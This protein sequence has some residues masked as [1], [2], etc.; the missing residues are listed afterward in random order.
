VDARAQAAAQR[1]CATAVTVPP[2]ETSGCV[3][4]DAVDAGDRLHQAVATHG[5]VHV[6]R[7]QRR[8][9]EPG[10][11]NVAYDDELEDVVGIAEAIG[12]VLDAVDRQLR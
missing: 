1:T 9:L 4:E 5:F 10:Q 11:P 2:G 3:A 7:V 6:H 12:E 8:R